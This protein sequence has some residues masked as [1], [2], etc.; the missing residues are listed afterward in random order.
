MDIALL[1]TKANQEIQGTLL[2][3]GYNL[4]MEGTVLPNPTW[5]SV[6]NLV[7]MATEERIELD[8]RNSVVGVS[9][10]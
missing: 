5:D 2:K 3:C 1:T 6:A 10:E 7:S 8:R 4:A 9:S